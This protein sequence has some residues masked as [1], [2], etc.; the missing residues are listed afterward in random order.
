[1]PQ[2]GSVVCTTD[3]FQGPGRLH[4]QS[5]LVLRRSPDDVGPQSNIASTEGLG[6]RH[7]GRYQNI[8]RRQMGEE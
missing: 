8:L 2:N 6:V 3:H 1:M 5:V 7:H 4:G